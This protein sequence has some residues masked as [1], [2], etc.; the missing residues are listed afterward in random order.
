MHLFGGSPGTRKAPVNLWT[1]VNRLRKKG[2]TAVKPRKIVSPGSTTQM[3]M[4]AKFTQRGAVL[5]WLGVVTLAAIASPSANAHSK[6][7]PGL[8]QRVSSG[9][10]LIKT[11]TCAG[12]P[13]GQGSGFLVGESVVMTARHVVNDACRVRVHVAGSTYEAKRWVSWRGSHTSAS[14]ADVATIKLDGDVSSGYVFRIRSSLPP[15]GSNVSAIGYPLG[16]RLSLN[17]GKLV[18][19]GRISGAPLMEIRMLGA[20]GGSGSAFVDDT[21]RVLGILQIGLGSKDV[22][23]QRTSGVLLGLDLVRW[24]GPRARLDLCRAYPHGGI[25][26]C[27]GST[28]PATPPPPTPPP[29]P[30]PPAYHVGGCWS[31]YTGASWASVSASNAQSSF[32]GADIGA[33]GASNFW[34]V[35]QLD[36]PTTQDLTTVS[37]TLIEPNGTWFSSLETTNWTAGSQDYQA[38]LDWTWGS[39]QTLFFQHPELTG[40]GTWTLRWTFPDG[41]VCTNQITIS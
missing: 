34:S 10:A 17:Q 41:E 29:V 27:P 3:A 18:A 23:G 9:V 11:Y 36:S 8:F 28:P 30:P 20:E 6:L 26:G 1:G 12:R 31:Q 35:V 25:A 7:S 39:D 38:S 14:A 13:I 22:F 37:L 16:N 21:G 4:R 2:G 24:W 32:M 5:F 40:Q 15:V 19:R 33:R